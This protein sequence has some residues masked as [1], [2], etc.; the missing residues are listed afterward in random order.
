MRLRRHPVHRGPRRLQATLRVGQQ[1]ML[2]DHARISLEHG[3]QL[4]QGG[5]DPLARH[6]QLRGQPRLLG[7]IGRVG[8]SRLLAGPRSAD[9]R[10]ARSKVCRS[11]RRLTRLSSAA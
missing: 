2:V 5:V 6:R 9:T 10:L 11:W 3:V 8:P 1:P 4:Q 7:R